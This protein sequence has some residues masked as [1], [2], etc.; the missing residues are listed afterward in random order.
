[1]SP[2]EPN[3]LLHRRFDVALIDGGHGWP[4]VF[5]DFC[6]ANMMMRSGSVL[7]LDDIQIYAVG[8]L[9]RLL[10][11]QPGFTLK[12]EIGKLQVW[13]KETASPLPTRTSRRAVHRRDEQ[14][15]AEQALVAP[16]LTPTVIQ[17]SPPIVDPIE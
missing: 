11:Q 1:M 14:E 15:P 8:E 16:T 17:G 12:E 3:R 9:A 10:E 5:V 6:Y 2:A 13:E 7:L 4:T